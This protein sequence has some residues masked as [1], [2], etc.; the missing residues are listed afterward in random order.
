MI[1]APVA[2][3]NRGC[4]KTGSKRCFNLANPAGGIGAGGIIFVW[5]TRFLAVNLLRRFLDFSMKVLYNK[6]E[7]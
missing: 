3:L 2:I 1:V 4:L 5:L 7:R 6:S